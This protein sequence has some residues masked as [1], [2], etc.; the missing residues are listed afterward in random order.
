MQKET[1]YPKFIYW[2]GEKDEPLIVLCGSGDWRKKCTLLLNKNKPK[3]KE[4]LSDVVSRTLWENGY[5]EEK[6]EYEILH[7]FNSLDHPSMADEID[8]EYLLGIMMQIYLKLEVER[9]KWRK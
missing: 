6:I 7:T 1:K 2:D 3:Q 4:E 5:R 9:K 8:D